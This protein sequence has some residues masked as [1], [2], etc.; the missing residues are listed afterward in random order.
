[1]GDKFWSRQGCRRSRRHGV[2]VVGFVH[3]GPIRIAVDNDEVVVACTYAR[4]SRGMPSCYN[5]SWLL[6]CHW[7]KRWMSQLLI[8]WLMYPGEQH[9]GLRE[10]GKDDSVNA[11]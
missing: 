5:A 11:V 7:A 10:G 6:V 8:S 4:T 3:Y 9:E 1:M 2:P